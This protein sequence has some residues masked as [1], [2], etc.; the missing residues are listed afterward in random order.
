MRGLVTATFPAGAA[1]P[2]PAVTP[3]LELFAS[4]VGVAFHHQMFVQRSSDD[5]LALRLS[6][7]RFRLAFDNAPIG[8]AEFI[9]GPSGLEVA[10][11]N[12]AASQ[13]FGVNVLGPSTSRS[14]EC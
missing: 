4:Q 2:N 3:M 8:M 10:R 7:E 5:H 13:M 1:R 14:T 9:E 6:E 11:I 12:R